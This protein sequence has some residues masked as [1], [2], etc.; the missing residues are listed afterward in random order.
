MGLAP[1]DLYI[2]SDGDNAT[3]YDTDGASNPQSVTVLFSNIAFVRMIGTARGNVVR[4]FFLST[5]AVLPGQVLQIPSA[6]NPGYFVIVKVLQGS[7]GFIINPGTEAAMLPL[8]YLVSIIR[9]SSAQ[10]AAPRNAWFELAGTSPTDTTGHIPGTGVSHQVRAG[11]SNSNDPIGEAVVGP[12]QNGLFT[13]YTP[14]RADIQLGDQ[15]LL[16]DGRPAQ[17]ETLDT[18]YADGAAYALQPI[19]RVG[20]GSGLSPT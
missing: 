2:G 10:Q 1:F 8:P 7:E 6:P 3:L 13:A 18:L 17:V 11:F 20:A 9:P 15:V 19:L 12:T 14:V 5:Q 16:L 4:A